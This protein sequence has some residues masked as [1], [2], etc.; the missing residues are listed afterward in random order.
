MCGKVGMR[1]VERGR[2]ADQPI[3]QPSAEGISKLIG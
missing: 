2:V 1:V 3:S